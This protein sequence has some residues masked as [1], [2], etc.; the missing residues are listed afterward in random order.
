MRGARIVARVPANFRLE[1]SPLAPYPRVRVRPFTIPP[2][3]HESELLTTADD[4]KA[5]IGE[6]MQ[7]EV[8]LGYIDLAHGRFSEAIGRFLKSLAFFQWAEVPV[9]EALIICG[10][11]DIARRQ[12]NL[13]EALHWYECALVPAGKD[14]NPMM[15]ST[16]VQHLAAIAF[17][18]ERFA[19][20]E[21]RYGELITFKRAMLDESGLAEALEWQGLSQERQEAYDRA[22]DS[23]YESALICKSFDM[24]GTASACARSPEARLSRPGHAG[25][26]R[27]SSTRNGRERHQ[28][29]SDYG[30]LKYNIANIRHPENYAFNRVERD[31]HARTEQAKEAKP[32]KPPAPPPVPTEPPPPPN[33]KQAIAAALQKA[34]AAAQAMNSA[35]QTAASITS[36]IADPLS[37]VFGAAGAAADEKMSQL[38][39]GL[40]K[41]LGPFPAATLTGIALGIPHAHVK[42]PPSGPPPIPPIPLPPLGPIMLGTN[43][44]VLINSKPT[45][46]CGDYGL[47]PTCCGVV[48]PLSALYQIVTG[49][50]NVYIGG[51][52]AARS[53]ID[54]TMHCF[55]VPSPKI[56]HQA[57]QARGYRQQ[58]REGREGGREGRRRC[59]EGRRCDRHGGSGDVDRVVVRRRGGRRRRRDGVGDRPERR[60]DGGAGGR[61]CRRRRHDQDDRDRSA[62]DHSDRHARHDSDGVAER[63][64]RRLPAAVVFGHRAGAV[65][66]REGREVRRRVDAGVG[67]RP[68]CWTD[69]SPSH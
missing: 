3:V 44:T 60:D 36:K 48:P 8:Q 43:V 37:A 13:K 23:W 14:G 56:S 12:D 64:D 59:G 58:G 5:P 51:S 4:P 30:E 61:R 15:I 11:G 34:N 65:E 7:A 47:N 38:V 62:G 63:D 41:A 45:A 68:A 35:A 28:A 20:A 18:Q 6:R 27:S 67:C 2:D 66:A 9:M 55:N 26:A 22:V 1:T 54:I 42:H 46:R 33:T 19:D 40:A 29:M 49:S 39:S 24:T 25:R 50:S 17:Q 69:M 16:I 21:E 31:K 52:R 10:L 32:A 53:G 57:R